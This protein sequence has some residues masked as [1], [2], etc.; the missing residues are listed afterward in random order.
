MNEPYLDCSGEISPIRSTPKGRRAWL[1]SE[2]VD[3]DWVV[4]L[5]A[6]VVDEIRELAR[7]IE[8]NPVQNLQRSVSDFDLPECTVAVGRLKAILD[9][10]VGFAVLDRLPMDEFPIE[11]LI[12]VYWLLGQLIGRPVAQKWNGQM[13]YDV[14]DTGAAYQY[15]VRGSHTSV[16]LVFHTDNAF[17]RM[18]PDYVGLLC[19]HPAASGGVSR[20]CSLYTVHDRMMERYPA[21]LERLYQPMF[22]DRQKEHA[23]GEAK[24]CLAPY[25]SWRG[26]RLFARANSS[27][28]RKGYEVVGEPMDDALLAALDAIDEV[29]S[30]EEIWFE[31]PLQRG[32]IQ[33][34]NNHEVGHYRSEF[35]DHDDPARKRHL[36]R[37]WHRAEGSVCYDGVYPSFA[38]ERRSASSSGSLSR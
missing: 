29:C 10:G 32:Q 15:G 25:F 16:E 11:S 28:V 18:V 9:D 14:S 36:Y 22:F 30:S 31:G 13:I 21:G 24:V 35:V 1:A 38:A 4:P 6:P 2:I 26:E 5:G 34:L 8:A 19:R 37:L 27:L 17:A 3:E 23:E 20:F 12:E 33:Y 7:F